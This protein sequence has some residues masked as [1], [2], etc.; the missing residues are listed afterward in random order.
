MTKEDIG[1]RLIQI[2]HPSK[3]PNLCFKCSTHHGNWLPELQD[4]LED[5]GAQLIDFC[6]VSGGIFQ[7]KNGRIRLE[8][9]NQ[10]VSFDDLAKWLNA[11]ATN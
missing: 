8:S 5:I 3:D 7:L 2:A 4:L 1:K 10:C 9:G 11:I 6:G